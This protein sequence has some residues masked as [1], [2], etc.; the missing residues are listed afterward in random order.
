MKRWREPASCQEDGS[1]YGS[2]TL[3]LLLSSMV[4]V[5]NASPLPHS[6]GCKQYRYFWTHS[7]SH[8]IVRQMSA[9]NYTSCCYRRQSGPTSM[10]T[11]PLLRL[12]L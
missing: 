11:D 8:C 2:P 9:G 7:P 6:R 1:N 10:V 12:C 5:S 3:T 4:D